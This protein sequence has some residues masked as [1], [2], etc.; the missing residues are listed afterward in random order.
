MQDEKLYSN[1][2]IAERVNLLDILMIP[3][4]MNRLVNTDVRSN[5]L[6]PL[7]AEKLLS[8]LQDITCNMQPIRNKTKNLLGNEWICLSYF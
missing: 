6:D 5:N 3:N 4:L 2:S 8:Y 7:I 1:L